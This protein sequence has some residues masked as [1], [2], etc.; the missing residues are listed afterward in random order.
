MVSSKGGWDRTAPN[1]LTGTALI[2]WA[3]GRIWGMSCRGLEGETGG[4]RGA[5][6][7]EQVP[8]VSVGE[9]RGEEGSLEEGT[10]P[11]YM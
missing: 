7:R 2:V 10:Q 4:V 3:P 11:R 9:N 8:L 5:D 6:C 1:V